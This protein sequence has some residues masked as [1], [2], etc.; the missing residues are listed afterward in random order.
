LPEFFDLALNERIP[1]A[2]KNRK[3]KS[4]MLAEFREKNQDRNGQFLIA[5]QKA[6][7]QIRSSFRRK[8][9]SSERMELELLWT[10][11][12][13]GVTTPD[14]IINFQNKTERPTVLVI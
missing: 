11:V 4:L 14:K 9:E 6:R 12:F 7:K 2:Q 10:P 5:S 8:P 3:C 1:S 13:T